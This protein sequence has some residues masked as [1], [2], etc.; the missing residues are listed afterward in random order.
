[1]K[2]EFSSS[3][4]SLS[5]FSQYI[6]KRFSF[7]IVSRVLPI[8]NIPYLFEW[9]AWLIFGLSAWYFFKVSTY[10]RLSAYLKVFTIFSNMFSVKS[11]FHISNRLWRKDRLCRL[12]FLEATETIIWK[13]S[14]QTTE[15]IL[16]IE[17]IFAYGSFEIDSSSISDDPYAR[18]VSIARIASVVLEERFHII[19]SVASKNFKRQRG[20]LRQRRLNG[21]QT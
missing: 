16:A 15:A 17:K 14:S 2:K 3:S 6:R 13:R 21:N 7:A 12:K 20:S 11:G 4:S 8:T 5:Q 10:S 9:R 19:V 18:I 1:M